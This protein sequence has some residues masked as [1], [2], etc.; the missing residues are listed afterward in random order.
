MRTPVSRGRVALPLAKPSQSGYSRHS[1]SSL[2]VSTLRKTACC[3][4]TGHLHA[5]HAALR[6][7]TH[8]SLP[9]SR[10]A[11]HCPLPHA[12]PAPR[13]RPRRGGTEWGG[14]VGGGASSSSTAPAHCRRSRMA[15]EPPGGCAIARR[16]VVA[17]AASSSSCTAT[18]RGRRRCSYDVLE[19]KMRFLSQ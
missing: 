14:R 6:A 18:P 16:A 2:R 1:G 11:R 12:T 13:T 8:P 17:Y 5:M 10:P 4:H 7:F 19:K 15:E 9:P 3:E